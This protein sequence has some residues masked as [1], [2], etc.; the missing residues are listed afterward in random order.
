MADRE[1]LPA[2]QKVDLQNPKPSFSQ[3]LLAWTKEWQGIVT[4]LAI[5]LSGLYAFW[6][7]GDN[8]EDVGED[9]GRLEK[10]LGEQESRLIE[11]LDAQSQLFTEKTERLHDRIDG[12]DEKIDHV[13]KGVNRV[14]DRLNRFETRLATDGIAPQTVPASYDDPVGT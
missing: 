5:L 3:R 10:S 1:T 8:I 9:V 12:V 13:D 4:F 6:E 11:K 7:M 2:Q 14:D